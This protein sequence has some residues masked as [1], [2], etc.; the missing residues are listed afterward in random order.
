[1][2][3]WD[4][5]GYAALALIAAVIAG[6]VNAVAGGGTIVSFP[7]LVWLGLPP[8]EANVTSTVGLWPGGISSIWGFRR[9]FT[10]RTEL[11]VWLVLPALVGGALGAFL[12]LRTPQENFKLIAPYLV[13]GATAVLAFQRPAKAVPDITR[14]RKLHS[15]G[16]VV[17]TLVISIYGGY[18]GAGLG[19][20]LL[21]TLGLLGM[22]DLNKRNGFK[23]LYTVAIRTIA[24]AYFALSGK[25]VWPAAIL[26]AVGSLGGGWLGPVLQ[27]RLGQEWMHRIIIALGIAMG[28]AMLFST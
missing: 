12:L 9:E 22:G 18:F 11:G 25:V 21:I 3:L 28:V 17:A 8:V 20:L 16:A 26:M 5:L 24:V 14:A 4:S 6:I 19:M 10:S 27:Y 1:M 15:I 2:S 23:N 13:L 7:V